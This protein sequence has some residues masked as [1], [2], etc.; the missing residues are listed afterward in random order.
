MQSSSRREI[1]LLSDQR[2]ALFQVLHLPSL[3]EVPPTICPQ[4]RPCAQHLDFPKFLVTNS[5]NCFLPL[6][7]NEP[8]LLTRLI[9]NI[10]AGE[11][12]VVC[13][14]LFIS[15]IW[16]LISH[17]IAAVPKAFDLNSGN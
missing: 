6:E 8:D 15:N 17:Q 4:P 11:N 9:Q 14:P 12:N 2:T 5:R 1:V 7:L 13:L 10:D 16:Y 3:A